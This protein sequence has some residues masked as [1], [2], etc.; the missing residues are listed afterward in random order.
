MNTARTVNDN[1]LLDQL[2][3]V[4]D[5]QGLLTGADIGERY[6][7]D[8]LGARGATPLAVLRPVDTQQVSR[9]LAL[10]HRHGQAIVTQGGRTGL[11]RGQLPCAGEMVLS[12]E[13]LNAIEAVDLDGGTA[14][15]QAGVVLQALQDHMEPLGMSFPL[16]LGGRGSCT[17]GG[18]IATNAGGNRVIRWGMTRDLVVGLEVV[19]A[20]GTVLDGLKTVLKNNTGLDLKQLFIGSEGVYGVITRAVLR[21]VPAPAERSVAFCA[22]ADFD[23]VRALLRHLRARLAGELTAFEVLWA[24]YYGR[25]AGLAGMALPLAAGQAFYVLTEASGSDG[26]R[27]RADQERALHEALELGLVSDAVVAQSGAQSAQL[28]RMRDLAI[29]VCRQ[30]DPIVPFDISVPIAGMAAF[31]DEL[32]TLLYQLDRRCECIVFGHVGD[33]NLHLAVHQPADLADGF[34]RIERTVYGLVQR[35]QGSVSAEHG[36]GWLK[37]AFLGCSRSAAEIS[38]MRTLK[39]ALDPAR[40]LNR[41]RIFES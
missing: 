28:W 20:D 3:T 36:I 32:A 34:E 29:E 16:D 23:Q 13:R 8:V 27:L 17:V 19:L 38:T 14:T 11:A 31:T 6:L 2:A 10:C 37:R 5:A 25:A 12:L 30:I 40:I 39:R 22:A 15:V 21:L 1:P 9:V 7:Q 26:P 24:S 41:D 33:G 18:N 35:Y 4:L